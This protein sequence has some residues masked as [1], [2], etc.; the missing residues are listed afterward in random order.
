MICV[1]HRLLWLE[2][3]GTLEPRATSEGGGSARM[4]DATGWVFTHER[5]NHNPAPE[6]KIARERRTQQQKEVEG[7]AL[8]SG[9]NNF[10]AIRHARFVW[11]R[12][13]APAR[14]GSK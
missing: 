11:G 4:A 13:D 3:H 14:H 10:M 1:L 8:T 6:G 7:I 2:A 5:E 12:V 9:D